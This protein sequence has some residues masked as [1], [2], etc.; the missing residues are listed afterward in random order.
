[1]DS[2]IAAG[3]TDAHRDHLIGYQTEA[4]STTHAGKEVASNM[5]V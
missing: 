1:M 4:Y 3:A 2:K 5:P